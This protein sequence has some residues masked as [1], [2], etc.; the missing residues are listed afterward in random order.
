MGNGLG[1][2]LDNFHCILG[3]KIVVMLFLMFVLSCVLV[4]CN[5]LYIQYRTLSV[6]HFVK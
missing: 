5:S 3:G 2:V 6:C 1:M 4:F